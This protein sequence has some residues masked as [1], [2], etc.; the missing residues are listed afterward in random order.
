MEATTILTRGAAQL[1]QRLAIIGSAAHGCVQAE[2]VDVGAQP[3]LE[4]CVPRHCA[5]HRQH[6]LA[7]AWAEGDAVSARGGLQRPEHAGL[8]RIGVAVSHIGL[9]LL[10]DKHPPTGEQPLGFHGNFTAA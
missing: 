7:G 3:L 6:L 2:S 1:L 9:A 5:L 10:F 8:V 4:V